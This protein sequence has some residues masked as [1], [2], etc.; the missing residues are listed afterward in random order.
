MML[1]GPG[2]GATAPAGI[3]SAELEPL[4]VNY[5]V[6]GASDGQ[7]LV[8]SVCLVGLRQ[9]PPWRLSSCTWRSCPWSAGL[10]VLCLPLHLSRKLHLESASCGQSKACILHM[11]PDDCAARATPSVS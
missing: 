3:G 7:Y 9:Q 8:R 1:C 4:R 6:R 11:S 2:L 10:A 5:G